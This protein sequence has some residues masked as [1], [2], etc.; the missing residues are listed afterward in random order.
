L[1]NYAAGRFMLAATL[2]CNAES[3]VTTKQFQ[4]QLPSNLIQSSESLDMNDLL[5]NKRVLPGQ[6]IQISFDCRCL[7][8]TKEFPGASLSAHFENEHGK[9][10]VENLV[11]EF[12]EP[13]FFEDRSDS[14]YP[15]LY[16]VN[17]SRARVSLAEDVYLLYNLDLPETRTYE[18]YSYAIDFNHDDWIVRG[19]LAAEC[20]SDDTETSINVRINAVPVRPG[21]LSDFPILTLFGIS[22]QVRTP[23]LTK[24]SRVSGR[25][26][27]VVAPPEHFAVAFP[28]VTPAKR[29]RVHI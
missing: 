15:A 22:Q 5:L 6:D 16:S 23:I 11:L 26:V 25:S 19:Q 14:S 2:R 10:L 18:K 27:M 21:T 7:R 24:L 9:E 17:P 8:A 29:T 4:L 12:K 13:A 3:A 20:W 1:V 28:A